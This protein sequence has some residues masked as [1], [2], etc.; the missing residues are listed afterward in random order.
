MRKADVTTEDSV[1]G[2][3][4]S[5]GLIENAVML[6][7]RIIRT[8]KCHIESS[9]QEALRYDSAFLPWLVEH[10]E[11]ILPRR[12]TGR[13]GKKPFERWHGKKPSEEFAECFIGNADG[14]SRGSRGFRRLEPQSRWDREAVKN[15]IGVPWSMTDGRWTVD[16]P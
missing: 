6:I 13:D 2:G 3:K 9:T 15:V 12:Q 5:N 14:V 8:I 1:K 4:P 11:S 7:C 10:A 16:R